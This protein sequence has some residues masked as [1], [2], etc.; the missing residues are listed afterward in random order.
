MDINNIPIK[1]FISAPAFIFVLFIFFYYWYLSVRECRRS[2]LRE[3]TPLLGQ[4]SEDQYQV[5]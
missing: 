1:Y 4:L 5:Y 3:S 2:R